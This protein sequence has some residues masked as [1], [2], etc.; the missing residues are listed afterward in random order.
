MTKV[1]ASANIS[2]WPSGAAFATCCAPTTCAPPPLFSITT[3]CPHFSD[4]RAPM[5]RAMM[6]VTPPAAAVTTNVTVL[7]GYDWACAAAG[8]SR[9]QSEVSR[10]SHFVIGSPRFVRTAAARGG[11]LTRILAGWATARHGRFAA[12]SAEVRFRGV[13][14]SGIGC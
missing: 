14:R 10:Q 3:C 12:A 5:A 11:E 13:A 8:T 6:S 2:V 4:S 9:Q 7:F 1:P